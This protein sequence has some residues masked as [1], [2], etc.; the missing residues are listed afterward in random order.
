M[1]IIRFAEFNY[2]L[3]PSPNRRKQLSTNCKKTDYIC[4]PRSCR[5]TIPDTADT[6]VP[7]KK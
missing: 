7:D 5:E 2:F 3:S 6:T 1:D 4:I